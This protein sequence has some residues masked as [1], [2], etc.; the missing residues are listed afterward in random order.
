MKSVQKLTENVSKHQNAVV[1]DIHI[2]N[3]ETDSLQATLQTWPREAP[4]MV[5]RVVTFVEKAALHR[6][7]SQEKRASWRQESSHVGQ[8]CL[9]LIEMLH[10]IDADYGIKRR[11]RSE[12]IERTENPALKPEQTTPHVEGSFVDVEAVYVC[13]MFS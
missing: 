10:N 5:R 2:F 3:T 8:E 7:P 1:L 9:R 4:T 11:E 13:A 12:H 6:W